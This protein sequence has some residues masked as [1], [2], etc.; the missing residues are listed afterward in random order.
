M[1]LYLPI[2]HRR[3]IVARSAVLFAGYRYGF[4]NDAGDSFPLSPFVC[5]RPILLPAVGRRRGLAT[6]GA[7]NRPRVPRLCGTRRTGGAEH[8]PRPCTRNPHRPHGYEP[9]RTKRQFC[10]LRR[11]HLRRPLGP[12]SSRALANYTK[13]AFCTDSANGYGSRLKTSF[14]ANSTETADRPPRW[15]ATLH[16]GRALCDQVRGGRGRC[17]DTMNEIFFKNLLTLYDKWSTIILEVHFMDRERLQIRISAD[18]LQQI[19]RSAQIVGISKSEFCRMAIIQ[20]ITR[21]GENGADTTTRPIG[22]Q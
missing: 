6:I 3:G 15:L 9:S 2:K 19:E 18:L 14:V 20:Y 22:D 12:C 11:K 13:L 16:Q 8:R 21:M 5:A 1:M 17:V 10:T 4:T 7:S